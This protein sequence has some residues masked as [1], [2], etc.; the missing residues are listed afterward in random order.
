MKVRT[1]NFLTQLKNASLYRKEIV[2]SET[3]YFTTAILVRLYTEGYI[4]SFRIAQKKGF[5]NETSNAIVAVHYVN[6]KPLFNELKITSSPSFKKIVSYTNLCRV[7]G[8][9]S[10]FLFTTDKGLLNLLECQKYHVGGVLLFVN[11]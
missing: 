8:K 1:I 11:T 5:Q 10:L 4:L 2:K 9:K 7:L 3:N 6:N